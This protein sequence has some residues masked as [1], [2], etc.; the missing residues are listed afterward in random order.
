MFNVITICNFNRDHI[1]RFQ[2]ALIK[3]KMAIQIIRD[4]KGGWQSLKLCC[5]TRFQRAFSACG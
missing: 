3:D 2:I 4:T 1:K 5:D